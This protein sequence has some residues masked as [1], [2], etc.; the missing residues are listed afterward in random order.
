[1]PEPVPNATAQSAD[2]EFEALS[3]AHNY[4]R[5][6][7]R[8]FLPHLRGH[9]IE[10]GAGIGQ[11]T[12]QLIELGSVE[13]ITAIEPSAAFC[14]AFRARSPKLTLLHGIAQ[15]LSSD[16]KAD[17]LVSINVLEHIERDE[18]E[19]R[20][21]RD[22]LQAKGGALC[23]FVPARQEIYAPIDKDFG[24]FRRYSKPL[25]RSRLEKAG[26]ECVRLQYFNLVGY[27]LWW[28]NFR[29]LGHRAFAARSVSLFDRFVFPVT[30]GLE[31]LIAAPPIGQSLL[32]I[33]RPA[34]ANR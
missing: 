10:V 25:L 33:A 29:L 15:D 5:A 23:L 31:H 26:F 34:T 24:H 9:V 8:E 1:M 18:Q 14:A 16:T 19:L 32:V 30:N 4:R 7:L 6:L 21:Y 12:E 13:R 17:A 22:L 2:F 20:F 28:A 11:F 27:F 3:H